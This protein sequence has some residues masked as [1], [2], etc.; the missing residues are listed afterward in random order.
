LLLRGQLLGL[1]DLSR[2]VIVPDLN[3]GTFIDTHA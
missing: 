2:D 1:S 3:P